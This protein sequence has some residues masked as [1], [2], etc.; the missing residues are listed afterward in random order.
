MTCPQ[1][2]T[3]EEGCLIEGIQCEECI[4]M[5]NPAPE[6]DYYSDADSGL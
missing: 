1:K 3:V 2:V 6:P 5:S 4:E